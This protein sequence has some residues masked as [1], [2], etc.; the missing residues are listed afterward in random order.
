MT[1]SCMFAPSFAKCGAKQTGKANEESHGFSESRTS[2]FSPAAKNKGRAKVSSTWM[3]TH[4]FSSQ[5]TIELRSALNIKNRTN[6]KN[7]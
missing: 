7:Q 6:E 4:R 2:F 1:I 5:G 3:L